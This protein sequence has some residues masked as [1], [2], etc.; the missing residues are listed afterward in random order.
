M[1]I[2]SCTCSRP[3]SDPF[4]AERV[5]YG[6]LAINLTATVDEDALARGRAIPAYPQGVCST[7]CHTHCNFVQPPWLACY[8]PAQYRVSVQPATRNRRKPPDL[9]PVVL[10]M[11]KN[12]R[13]A[14]PPPRNPQS[15][16]ARFLARPLSASAPE[17]AGFSAADGRR[18]LNSKHDVS[19][20][21]PGFHRCREMNCFFRDARRPMSYIPVLG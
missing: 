1:Y 8:R 15:P 16:G 17:R 18:S 14:L 20:P 2:R 5:K 6:T 9:D 11:L 21:S 4:E 19:R 12:L 13:A 3:T 10:K 7:Q